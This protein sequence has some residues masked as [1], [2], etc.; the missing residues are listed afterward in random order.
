MN[1][2]PSQKQLRFLSWE[3]GMFFHFGIRTFNP[4][5]RDWDGIEMDPSTFN[6][7][8]LDCRQWL[9]AA[10]RIGARYAILTTKHHDGFALWP[11]R[12]TR[13]SVAASPWKGGKGDVVKEFTDA[14]REEGVAIG[15]YYSP[16]QWGSWAVKF[17]DEKQ[18]DD[19]FI[20]QI[21]ELLT[22]Y[23]KIDY[24]WF[25]GCG[26]NGHEYDQKRI[27]S[28]IRS[29]QP[30]ILIFDMW[31]PDTRWVGNEDG[32]APVPNP[33][34]V[35]RA[36]LGETKTVFA[37][38]ECD[39]KLREHWFWDKDEATVKS[40]DE[41]IGMYELSVGRGSNLL[42]NVGPDRRGLI[43]EPDEKRLNE[44]GALISARYGC[45]LGF[46]A[47]VKEN[48][49]QYSIQYGQLRADD[50]GDHTHLPL[51]ES[52]V[53]EEDITGGQSVKRFR[54]WAHLPSLVPVSDRR[55]CVYEG[56]TVGHKAICRFP[57]IRTP[58]LTLEILESDGPAAIKNFKAY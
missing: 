23:G 41:L 26:S 31:D 52:A 57:S 58:R 16:A 55:V 14:C 39:C 9:R 18:Y 42:L 15:L 48:E 20:S 44:L 24:I 7:E 21:T 29:L 54:L 1:L 37:P 40:L 46:G 30:D 11:S 50:M 32:Y 47:P 36:V 4:G 43:P 35:E 51:C 5:H 8:F 33:Y 25:D 2:T 34:V 3:V 28:V 45:P 10:K 22:G 38:A 12:F 56:E 13:Y 6:P 49:N 17:E 19:Y 27:V 53:I